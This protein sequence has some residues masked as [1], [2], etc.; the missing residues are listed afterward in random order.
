[1]DSRDARVG[2]EP[3]VE[4]GPC[5]DAF[6][7]CGVPASI[8]EVG[9][10]GDSRFALSQ[11]DEQLPSDGAH[12]RFGERIADQPAFGRHRANSCR[13]GRGYQAGVVFDSRHR[14]PVRAPPRCQLDDRPPAQQ[15]PDDGEAQPPWAAKWSH[16]ATLTR[17]GG[18]PL[19]GDG[20]FT[21]RPA[22]LPSR[23]V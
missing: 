14:S 9:E 15:H 21:P 13:Q 22:G 12:Q 20:P 6:R 10:V 18:P 11:P 23:W 4:P 16:E 1:M 19:G 3:V 7:H 5:R 8:G 2:E 17:G